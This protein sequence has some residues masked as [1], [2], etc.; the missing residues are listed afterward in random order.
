MSAEAKRQVVQSVDEL[1]EQGGAAGGGPA[2]VRGRVAKLG[3]LWEGYAFS[4][5]EID[6]ARGEVWAGLGREP[7]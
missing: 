3:G 1:P 7:S 4:A 2:G 5:E 6:E